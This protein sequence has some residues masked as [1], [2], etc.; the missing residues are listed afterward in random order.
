MA[1]QAIEQRGV[2]QRFVCGDLA[3][4]WLWTY[5]HDRPHTALISTLNHEA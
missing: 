1:Q 5:N 3:T 2:S 4:R